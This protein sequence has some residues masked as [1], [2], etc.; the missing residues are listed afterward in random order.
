M[1]DRHQTWPFLR[2]N[3]E[4]EA[5]ASGV[6]KVERVSVPTTQDHTKHDW[7]TPCASLTYSGWLEA[8]CTQ[9]GQSILFP[10]ELGMDAYI[11]ADTIGVN[12]DC[13]FCLVESILVE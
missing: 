9:C 6:V 2:L 12:Q 5:P 11:A 13:D 3:L 8:D 7:S 4:S 1:S 10:N